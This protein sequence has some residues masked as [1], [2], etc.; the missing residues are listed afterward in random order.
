MFEIFYKIK[1]FWYDY[2]FEITICFLLLFFLIGAIYQKISG[3]KGT[4]SSTYFYDK[5]FGD[6]HKIP[7]RLK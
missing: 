2:N 6:K 7:F 5:Y 1:E 4:W 3:K